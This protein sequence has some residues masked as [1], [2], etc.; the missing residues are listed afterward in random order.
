MARATVPT[1]KVGFIGLGRMGSGIARRVRAA[2][3]PL[4]VYDSNDSAM[5]DAVAAGATK[6]SSPREVAAAAEVILTSLPG[7]PEIRDVALG[8]NGILEG[9]KPRAA[10]FD[11]S[12]NSPQLVAEMARA[13]AERG[14]DYLDAPVS[15]GPAGAAS[16]RLAVWVGGEKAAFGRYAGLLH[17]LG[18]RVTYVGP[19]GSGTIAKLVHNSVAYACNGVFAELF[20]LGVKAG[21]DPLDLWSTVREGGVGRRRTF[22]ALLDHFLS[23]DYDPPAFALA[24]ARK[25]VALTVEAARELG[26]ALPM[27]SIALD[28]MDEAIRRGWGARDSRTP[29]LLPQEHAGISIEVDAERIATARTIVRGGG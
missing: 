21:M 18:D 22:D 1:L 27:T 24:L 20:T 19:I 10:Y 25:D 13:F 8:R 6:G 7:P 11:L 16:G 29:M 17:S 23:G 14:V 5:A 28:G 15:G 3:Y 12:T 2:G 4:V 26:V 9:A